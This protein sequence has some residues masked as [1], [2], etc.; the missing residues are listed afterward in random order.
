MAL[1]KNR[2]YKKG[3]SL[4]ELLLVLGVIAGLIVSAF[5]IYPKVQ[6][7][8]RVEM[9]S[10]NI[11]AIQAGVKA[12]YASAPNYSGLNN[13]VALNASVFP[14]TMLSAE[15]DERKVVNSFK[16]DVELTV[17]L[18]S[19]GG[20]PDS[21]FSIT[22]YGVP[23]TECIKLIYAV[24]NNFYSVL[25]NRVAVSQDSYE[26]SARRCS[27]TTSNRITFTSL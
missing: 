16:G 25:I 11:A 24:R 7:S 2:K 6:A 8:Q 26:F 14:D 15:E 1:L 4:L 3:F 23:S 12:L 27:S 13:T 20:I 9:E 5:I 17:G 10:K 22:Y 21:T 19:P 18:T